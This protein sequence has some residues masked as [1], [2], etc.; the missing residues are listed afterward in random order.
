M[1]LGSKFY[2]SS[3]FAQRKTDYFENPKFRKILEALDDIY[4]STIS[5]QDLKPFS[6]SDI[7]GF[8]GCVAIW[9]KLSLS[10]WL[11]VQ[12]FRKT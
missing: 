1:T 10:G 2:I 7:L 3:V 5:K 6:K 8:T 9:R 4:I 11:F 12:V